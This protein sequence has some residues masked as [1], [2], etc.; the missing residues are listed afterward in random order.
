MEIE[1][2]YGQDPQ[3]RR[4]ICPLRLRWGL[5]ERQ[6]ISPE[7]EERLCLAAV[8]TGSYE[9]AAQ[10]AARFGSSANDSLIHE[11]VR[12][13]GQ[14]AEQAAE[15]RTRK[16]LDPATRGQVIA[17]AK[18]QA[19]RKGFDLVVMLDGWLMRHR[20]PQ[21]GLKPPEASAERVAWRE[22]KMAIVYRL[23]ERVESQ[24]GRGAIMEKFVVGWCGDPE[25]LGRRL[26]AEA[27]RRGLNQARRVYVVADGAV[28]IWNV[29]A[30]RLGPVAEVLDIMHAR[31]HLWVIARELHGQDEAK[32]RQ[33]AGPLSDLL[34]QAGGEK[35]L[36]A[37]ERLL[38]ENP[39]QG[40]A[41]TPAIRREVEYFRT[42]R[43]RMDYPK[44][45]EQGAPIGSGAMESTCAQFQ[46]R[47]K[48]P[49]QFWTDEGH[50]YLLA[51]DI[52]RRNGDWD[53][54]WLIAA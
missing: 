51:L 48:R 24:S 44:V 12:Q 20:G 54:A 10:V 15:E 17:Q 22:T 14:R 13:A 1:A 43:E 7:L 37:L 3:T 25:E 29:V 35:V 38:I 41:P 47:F 11:H 50:R 19:P 34:G 5:R 52:A 46:T 6:E 31:Q 8:M 49:G 32:V 28:W 30:D 4:W 26:Y 53:D 33:W 21:W 45:K 39:K 9:A 2:W 42:H 40:Y 18:A 23:A 36:P 16:A 27:L